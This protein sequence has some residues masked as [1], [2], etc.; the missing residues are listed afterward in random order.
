VDRAPQARHSQGSSHSGIG[1][2]ILQGPCLPVALA[3]VGKVRVT[4]DG[5]DVQTGVEFL[6]RILA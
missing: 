1:S 6:T 4:A 3:T 2:A 5:P